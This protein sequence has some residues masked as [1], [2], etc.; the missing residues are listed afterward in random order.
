MGR[1]AGRSARWEAGLSYARGTRLKP[2]TG[3]RRKRSC[4]GVTARSA[5]AGVGAGDTVLTEGT[6][7][8]F[9]PGVL[10]KIEGAHVS[11]WHEAGVG[12]PR[13]AHPEL[14]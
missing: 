4:V 5:L 3:V 9:D 6:G 10:G 14:G 1:H 13:L 2:P 11:S 7:G 8:V 12:A